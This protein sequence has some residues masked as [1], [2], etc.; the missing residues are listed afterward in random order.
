MTRQFKT[1]LILA[2]IDTIKDLK[3]KE[4]YRC[5]NRDDFYSDIISNW[6][7]KFK[8]QED[9]LERIAQHIKDFKLY[10]NSDMFDTQLNDHQVHLNINRSVKAFINYPAC[11]CQG[12]YNWAAKEIITK[13]L[14]ILQHFDVDTYVNCIR[15]G[16]DPKRSS[17]AINY[18]D[19][20][21]EIIDCLIKL[22]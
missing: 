3:S 15:E 21:D 17:N 16:E 1:A 12:F 10:V 6:K 4:D 5:Y 20:L 19:H 18:A 8:D 22:I 2:I 11:T 14:A 9:A 7:L 13:D